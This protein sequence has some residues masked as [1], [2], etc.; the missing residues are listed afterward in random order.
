VA[1]GHF[2]GT[3]DFGAFPGSSEA[4]VVVTAGM[5][6]V[7]ETSKASAY[8]MADDTTS[9][10]TAGDHRYAACF[11]Q[12]TCGTPVAGTNVTVYARSLDKTQGTFAF[13]GVWAD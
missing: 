6:S 4:S 10:H 11:I 12:L 5:S 9:D 3:I 13:R 2:S 1:S 7:S 8:F